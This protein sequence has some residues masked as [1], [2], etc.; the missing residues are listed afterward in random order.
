MDHVVD[1]E[2]GGVRSES[3]RPSTASSP[4][5]TVFFSFFFSRSRK[6]HA[7]VGRETIRLAVASRPG[8]FLYSPE[9]G[10]N[11]GLWVERG[12]ICGGGGGG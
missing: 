3:G 11:A 12:G 8:R 5:I 7:C 4:P 6:L 2:G 10:M 1:E 9:K